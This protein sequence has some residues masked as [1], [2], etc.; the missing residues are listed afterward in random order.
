MAVIEY[1]IQYEGGKPNVVCKVVQVDKGDRILFKAEYANT[2]IKYQGQSPF[3]DSNGPQAG[4]AV[5]VDKLLGPFEVKVPT[6]GT[7]RH[8]E[9]G[10]IE[11]AKTTGVGQ[12]HVTTEMVFKPWKGGGSDTP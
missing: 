7:P 12:P 3:Q 4:Q 2:G 1:D 9:C 5:M 6:Y 8:F 11:A 10:E